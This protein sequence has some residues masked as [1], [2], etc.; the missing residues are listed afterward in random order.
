MILF[1]GVYLTFKMSAFGLAWPKV[2]I[3]AF[4][5]M[6]PLG[7]LTA[8]RMRAI[9]RAGADA[10]SLNSKLLQQLQDPMLKISLGAVFLGILLL[11]VAKP[12][13]WESIG[14]IGT[15]VVL[16]LVSSLLA[17]LGSG[18]LSAAAPSPRI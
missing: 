15:A 7:A 10:H 18:G 12:E 14:I 4:L 8:R 11:M 13:L 6:A 5:L 1:S 17:W 2:T 9:R 16:G 3:A